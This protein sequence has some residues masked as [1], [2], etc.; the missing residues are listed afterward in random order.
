MREKKSPVQVLQM[1][2][3]EGSRNIVICDFR[4]RQILEDGSESKPGAE[5]V[6]HGKLSFRSSQQRSSWRGVVRWGWGLEG[7]NK[8]KEE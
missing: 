2:K 5:A 8:G 6:G 3:S 7:E 1:F 4:A